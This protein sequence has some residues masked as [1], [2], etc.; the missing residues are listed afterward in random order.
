MATESAAA[1]ASAGLPQFDPQ[2]W[3]GQIVWFLAIFV[4]VFFLM[5]HL[6][7]PRIGG[8][9]SAREDR[10]AGDIAA[11]RALKDE[12]DAQALAAQA[13]MV[14]VRGAAQKVASEAR[15]AAKAE[16][17]AALAVQEAKLAA[18]MEAA[19]ARIRNARDDAMTHVREIA[20]DTAAAIV[21]RLTGQAAS[22]TEINAAI[23]G[24]A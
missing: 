5:R 17:A 4:V 22:A 7:V 11:A 3:P 21:A 8:G 15:D 14:Q 1:D 20:A 16:I 23:G 9:I 18:E 24:R 2:W 13:E 6:F 10:I 12:A 19:E